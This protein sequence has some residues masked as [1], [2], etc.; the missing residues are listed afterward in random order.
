MND[1][2]ARVLPEVLRLATAAF[3]TRV[4]VVIA[5]GAGDWR[6]AGEAALEE[7]EGWHARLSRFSGDSLVSHLARTAHRAAVRLDADTVALFADALAV[8]R[9]SSGAFD[10]TLAGA[11]ARQGFP[12]S[13]AASVPG[14]HTR[15]D[16]GT[17]DV[18]SAAVEGGMATI[19]LDE[20]RWSVRFRQPGVMLDFGA[21]A[22]GHA[23]E[24]AA[25]TLRA[26]GITAALL[27][28]GTSSVVALGAPPGDAGWRVAIGPGAQRRALALA[29]MALSVSDPASQATAA[30]RAHILDPRTRAPVAARGI[31]AVTGPSARLAD[32]WSTALAVLGSVPPGFPEDYRALFS[33]PTTS[34]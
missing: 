30:A 1:E 8:W 25:R 32:A 22:K 18:A 7:V 12:P 27:H 5:A 33:Q 21:I 14:L 10:V 17:V 26:A 23:L 6:A 19:D 4:E 15:P 13:A 9:A 24:C 20:A 11:L 31:V 3:G 16:G 29:D 28:G 2:R 34:S